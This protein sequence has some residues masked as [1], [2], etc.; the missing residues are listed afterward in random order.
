VAPITD[1]TTWARGSGLEIVLFVSG[2][3]VLSRVT[4]WVGSVVTGRIE[5]RSA[6][7]AGLVRTESAKHGHV[8]A[9]VGM[10]A[11]IVLLFDQDTN[12]RGSRSAATATSWTVNCQ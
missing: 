9:Q 1:I 3:I 4:R 8:L 6:R 10:W 2:A 12:G 5:A 11:V 7:D